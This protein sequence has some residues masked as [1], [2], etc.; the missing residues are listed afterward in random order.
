MFKNVSFFR[1]VFTQVPAAHVLEES[2]KAH[3][4][5]PCVSS[6]EYSTGWVPPREDHG[7]LVEATSGRFCLTLASERRSVPVAYINECLE[8]RASEIENS[9]GRAVGRKA[10]SDLKAEIKLALIPQAF[11]RRSRTQV[12][13]HPAQGWIAIDS[14]S[15]STCDDVA[16]QLLAA[17]PEGTTLSPPMSVSA[18]SPLFEA[19]I[20]DDGS[21]PGDAYLGTQTDL[22]GAADSG[23]KSTVKFRGHSLSDTRVLAHLSAGKRPV[24]VQLGLDKTMFVMSEDLRFKALKRDSDFGAEERAKTESADSFDTTAVLQL[25]ELES[26]WAF[27][28]PLL[29]DVETKQ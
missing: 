21:L 23:E 12:M 20:R 25:A 27:V 22:T 4:F 11:P 1:V 6:Q 14:A 13:V 16:V 5:K 18:M 15:P 9:T 19:W 2:L 3:I 7:A 8:E 24:S 10:R 17:F 29:T 28:L 26:L